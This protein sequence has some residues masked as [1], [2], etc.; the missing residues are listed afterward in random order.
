[1]FDNNK[2]LFEDKEF[3]II[4]S[5]DYV[6][7]R[8]NNSYSFHSHFRKYS[9]A[10][11]LIK[12]FYKKIRPSTNY[13]YIAMQRVTTEQEFNNFKTIRLKQKYYNRK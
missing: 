5:C 10:I 2:I 6:V 7:I 8:K 1:M 4:R 12:L 13:F 9:G 3:K 11:G